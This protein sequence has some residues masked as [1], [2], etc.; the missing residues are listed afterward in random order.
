[1][2]MMNDNISCRS[3]SGYHVAVG[4]VAPGGGSFIRGVVASFLS[5][6]VVEEYLVGQLFSLLLQFSSLST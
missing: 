1:M 2:S 4:D 3:L 6:D 5:G